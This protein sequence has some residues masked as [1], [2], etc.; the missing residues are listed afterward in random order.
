MDAVVVAT[1]LDNDVT[2]N[3]STGE[4]TMK[5]TSVLKGDSLVKVG[6]ELVVIYYGE[7][8]AGR[9]FMLSGVD[10]P[11]LLWSCLPLSDSAVDYVKQIPTLGEDS[12]DRLKFYYDFLQSD[13]S[14]LSRDSYD[15]FAVAPY[16]TIVKM[17][18]RISR[19]D[20]IAWL[21]EPEITTDRKRLYLTLLGV[22]GS[23]E[24]LPMLETMLRST[25]K[26]TR[27]GLDALIACYL[28]LSGEEG[29]PM[30]EKLFLANNTASYTDTYSAVMAIRFHG[31]EGDTIAR[32]ALASS[33]HHLLDRPELADLVIPDL[34]RWNDWSVIEK[35]TSLFIESDPDNNWIRVPVVNYLRAC[36]LPEAE[37]AIDEL[38]KIDPEAVRRANTFYSV[39]VPARETQGDQ[40]SIWPP[41][42]NRALASNQ[43]AGDF[44]IAVGSPHRGPGSFVNRWQLAS[45]LA[46]AL[47]TTT[48]VAW[49]VL[50]GGGSAS[51]WT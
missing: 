28:T 24:D 15:E 21:R 29:L 26:S 25:Q 51:R 30:I 10:P 36:P 11:E 47:V 50:T 44:D 46:M 38:T 7:V 14:M 12:L 20:L 13:D 2:R 17:A 43:I 39:P 37:N 48:L 3:T 5:V 45:V 33:L 27:G 19:D 32:T 16:E 22:V 40:S 42:I 49:L 1:S 23:K 34:A 41:K 4:V 18:P 8:T 9:K 31:T 6:D 35:V